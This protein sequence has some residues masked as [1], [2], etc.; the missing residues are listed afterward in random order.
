MPK[1][2]ATRKQADGW[3]PVSSVGM[4]R[5]RDDPRDAINMN[6]ATL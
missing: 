1:W 5:L 3:R 6:D 2:D 4:A